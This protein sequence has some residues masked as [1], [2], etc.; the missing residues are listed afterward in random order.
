[1]IIKKVYDLAKLYNSYFSFEEK[2]CLSLNCN[3]NMREIRAIYSLSL[4]EKE[5]NN[6]P[7]KL[8]NHLG[9]SPCIVS[10]ILKSLISKDYLQKISSMSD[11]RVSYLVLTERGRELCFKYIEAHQNAFEKISEILTEKQLNELEEIIKSDI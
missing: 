11:K 7:N 5:K 3:L 8:A 1:M 4:L 6:T 10:L 2:C 9:V